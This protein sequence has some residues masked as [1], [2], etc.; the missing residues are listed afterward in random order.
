VRNFLVL[1][2][3]QLVSISYSTIVRECLSSGGFRAGYYKRNI[4][5]LE[6]FWG[7]E[8]RQVSWVPHDGLDETTAIEKYGVEPCTL[9]RYACS[10]PAGPGAD[11]SNVYRF[12]HGTQI[13]IDDMQFFESV[14]NEKGFSVRL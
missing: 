10:E 4:R 6:P 1:S 7:A 5:N 3:V 9:C 8:K 12:G 14:E 11:N 2:K 13:L